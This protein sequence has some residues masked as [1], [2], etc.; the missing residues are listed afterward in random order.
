MPSSTFVIR[1]VLPGSDAPTGT[2]DSSGSAESR[3]VIRHQLGASLAPH[4]YNTR[5][6]G[7]SSA[8]ASATS[9]AASDSA[10]NTSVL[11]DGSGFGP[12]AVASDLTM[13]GRSDITDTSYCAIHPGRSTSP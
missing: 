11:S 2:A 5:A 8:R 10:M 4:P 13:P 3:I 7:W 1:T 6:D 9:L 12:A